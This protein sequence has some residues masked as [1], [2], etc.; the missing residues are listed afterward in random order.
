MQ[1]EHLESG[2]YRAGRAD[3]QTTWSAEQ[4][5]T[6]GVITALWASVE[7]YGFVLVGILYGIR[8][9]HTVVE[10]IALLPFTEHG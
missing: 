10:D 6:K 4:Y 5:F 2:H 8:V 3:S 7:I 9:Q 1:N